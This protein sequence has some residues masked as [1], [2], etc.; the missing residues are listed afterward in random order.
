MEKAIAD[1]SG[2]IKILNFRLAKTDEIIE[3]SDKEALKRHKASIDNST[4]TVNTLKET[5]AKGETE[6]NVREWGAEIETNLAEADRQKRRIEKK[7]EEIAA[8]EKD[9]INRLEFMQ[10][11]EHEKLLTEQKLRQEQEATE[12]LHAEK[13][14]Y[15]REKIKLDLEYQQQ[16]SKSKQSASE[17]TT[18]S[19]GT[20]K[21]PKLVI[22]KF[23][24]TPQDWV[25]FWGQFE[26]QI[27][28]A[29][30][31]AVTKFSYLKELVELKVR[32]LID[33]LPFTD[34]GYEKAIALLQ[35]RYGRTDEIVNAYVKN[36]LELPHIKERDLAR[37]HEFYDSLLFNVES[38]QTLEKLNE[39]DA[40]VRFTLDKLSIIKHELA[41]LDENWSEW[42]FKKFVEV[43]GTWTVNNPLPA[44]SKSRKERLRAL[45]SRNGDGAPIRVCCYCESKTHKAINCDKVKDVGERKKILAAKRLCFNCTGAKHRASECK[46]SIS[47]RNCERKHHTS[48]CDKPPKQPPESREPGM[49]A[50]QIGQ[51]SVIHPVVVVK[52]NGLKFRALLDSGASHS[53]VSS[54]FVSLVKPEQKSSSVRQIA[55]L[56]G[57]TTKRLKTYDVDINSVNGD[58]SVHAAVTEIAKP[59]LLTLD[60][61]HYDKVIEQH[62]YLQGVCMD[63]TD[64][65]AQLPV[66]IIL[67]AN[68][69]ARIRTGEC[70]RVGQ[71][72]DPVAEHTSFGWTLMSPGAN[73]GMS[74]AYLAVNTSTDF[75]RLCALDVLGLPDTPAGDQGDVYSEFKEQLTRSP[76]GWYE[77]ALP[78]KGSHPEL[79]NNYDGSLRRLNSLTR[80][81]RRSNMLQDYDRI[82]RDQLANGII[83]V[84]PEH[85]SDKEF[86]IPHRPVVK[87]TSETTKLRIVYD[88]SARAQ[89]DAPSLNECLHAGPPLQNELWSVLVRS[90]LHP[91]ALAGDIR[92]AF[93][94]IRIRE[95]ERDALRFHWLVDLG[96][97]EVVTLR[98][99]RAL[100]GLSPSPFLL[101]G[102]IKQHLE[103][104]RDQLPDVVDEVSKSMYV[105]DFI[106]GSPTVTDAKKLKSETSRIFNDAQFDLHKWNSNV[107]ELEHNDH[108]DGEESFAKQQLGPLARG[109]ESKLLGLPWNKREDTLSVI[110]PGKS[111]D[112]TKR[113][114]LSA[115][116]SVYD[117]LGFVS[118]TM[119]E[120]KLVYREA[121]KQK[122]AW[123]APL[124]TKVI[125]LWMKFESKLPSSVS[126]Q[127]SLAAFQEPLDEVKI[128]AFGDASGK[129][130]SASVYAVVSQKSGTTQGLLT[131]KSRVAKQGLTIPRLELIAGHMAVNL[132]VNVR[133]SLAGLPI[134]PVIHCWLDSTVALHWINNQG[135]YRQ[136]VAN[137]VSKIQNHPN[138]T[139]RHVPT[140]DNPADIGSRG[141]SVIDSEMWWKGPTWLANPQEWPPNIVTQPSPESRGELKVQRELFAGAVEVRDDFYLIL[142]KFGLSKAMRICAWVSRFMHNSRHPSSKVRGPL[143]TTEISN[144]EVFWIKRAQKE[145]MSDTKF[146]EDRAQLNLVNNSDD[147][148]VCKGR[149]V[150]EYP[151]F[152]SDSTLL[153]EK[154]VAQAHKTT[155]HGGI[156]LT[157][158]E[159][160]Q[161]FWIPRLGKLTKRVLKSCW[162]CKRFRA[163]PFPNPPIA[164]LPTDRTQGSTAFDV[165]GVDF[166]GPIIYRRQP[167]KEDKAYVVLYSCSVT[168]AVFLE[169]LSSLEVGEFIQSLKRLI[170]RR[171]RPSKIYSD[172]AKT[173]VAAAKWLK[174]IQRDESFNEFLVGHSI[175]WQ[176]NLSRAP[177]WGGQFERLIGLM[178]SAFYKV[179][180][181]GLL[182]WAELTELLLDIEVTLNNRPLTYMEEDIQL[183]PLTPNSLLF[184]NANILPEL[185]PCHLE[186]KDLKKRAKFLLQCKRAM[187]KRWTSEYLRALR[188]QH[189]LKS[190]GTGS[191][192]TEGEVV[193]I[194]SAE[195]NKNHWPLGIIEKLIVGKD[196]YVRGAKVR[197]G[198]S[199][200]ERAVQFLYPM[201]LSCDKEHRVSTAPTK[202]LDPSVQPFRPR[203]AAAVRAEERIR[204]ITA[205]SEDEL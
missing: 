82:I 61:P 15:E 77:T 51:S 21:M 67:G 196:G 42:N 50:S 104:W 6:E 171:G 123:D 128:H 173:F 201:E 29:E 25:R 46:S 47:C 166:A 27:H 148:L 1:L 179:V 150:G 199:V 134:D 189:R 174:K 142:E 105:D 138:V 141:G 4:S 175:I 3:R 65:K 192:I 202:S 98:F 132:A 125:E 109:V 92:Q 91:V 30:A 39:I 143:T 165:I 17:S 186:Q 19:Q 86:Y 137:R 124:P 68:D 191:S 176:F 31:S 76:Q 37:I 126:T 40:A 97:T 100:F 107:E 34:A 156:T 95:S 93:L 147:I 172:N 75:E 122:T 66:H 127:R 163:T 110:F 188:E 38:L 11:L 177:W 89:P 96:S 181:Q 90:R 23:Q 35:K 158:A 22:S 10:K 152:I 118:P 120:G 78:W 161:K 63:D 111:S 32:K 41:L 103:L 195:R 14:S 7:L 155:L 102:V 59:E 84:A 135:D 16:L 28:K 79:P 55:M 178:K 20:V 112:M 24:G 49:T 43:L 56:M 180:G 58:F 160:R 183:P 2:K 36:I 133:H 87:E 162:G 116:A 154:L 144:Q 60:N 200:I 205:D 108:S 164:P 45:N 182:S 101:N 114:I 88:A 80:K 8:G 85:P 54:K 204:N 83:E 130:V 69:F 190:G 12:R 62:S 170:A 72:G 52:V 73:S 198:K 53:Y 5:I 64:E 70:L 203:R 151:V 48:L 115:L 119:L 81:L 57:T 26:A 145:G 33:G 168:R 169:L 194:K 197:T 146:A 13:L 18:S 71:H 44:D 74:Q 131:A 9:R 99:T 117:P 149:I 121:C 167:K 157:M 94:Q 113:G 153:A 140:I 129:G 184:L 136:F 187:W 106:S 185:A 159:I 139:W 193:I